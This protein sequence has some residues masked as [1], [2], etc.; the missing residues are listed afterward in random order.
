MIVVLHQWHFEWWKSSNLHQAS[1]FI[2]D[3][4]F[5]CLRRHPCVAVCVFP[6]LFSLLICSTFQTV[7]FASFRENILLA[8]GAELFESSS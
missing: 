8:L 1:L 2:Y 5:M 4:S 6:T 7:L 3:Y